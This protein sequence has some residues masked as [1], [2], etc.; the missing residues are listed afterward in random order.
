MSGASGG[1]VPPGS[2]LFTHFFRHFP[3]RPGGSAGFSLVLRIFRIFGEKEEIMWP[4]YIS[5][6]AALIAVLILLYQRYKGSIPKVL[7]LLLLPVL[8]PI[9]LLVYIVYAFVSPK[10]KRW[11]SVEEKGCILYFVFIAVM[12]GIVVLALS[13]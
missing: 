6:G 10:A 9:S 4:F 11:L 2:T 3:A 1:Q 5:G 7:A 12:I 13:L 8:L